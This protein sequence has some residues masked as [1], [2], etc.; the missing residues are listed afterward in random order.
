MG[1]PHMLAKQ[2]ELIQQMIDSAGNPNFTQTF[3]SSRAGGATPLNNN[4][5]NLTTT[6]PSGTFGTK[7]LSS[8]SKPP[9]QGIGNSNPSENTNQA[10]KLPPR[11]AGSSVV[12][13]QNSTKGNSLFDWK[14]PEPLPAPTRKERPTPT[15]SMSVTNNNDDL[16]AVSDPH[17]YLISDE[18]LEKQEKEMY[19]NSFLV[20]YMEREE[21][22]LTRRKFKEKMKGVS[23]EK[24]FEYNEEE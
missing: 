3:S 23:P 21:E 8:L 19:K 1:K 2:N 15:K 11:K 7:T 5:N 24:K 13:K 16:N 6:T 9:S 14:P 4:T 20:R 22:E 12:K 10:N 17:D 18:A